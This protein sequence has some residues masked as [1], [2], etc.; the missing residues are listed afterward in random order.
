MNAQ[1]SEKRIRPLFV[2]LLI[3]ALAAILIPVWIFTRSASTMKVPPVSEPAIEPVA[4]APVARQLAP[5]VQQRVPLPRGAAVSKR[6]TTQKPPVPPT[7]PGPV[8]RNLE[9]RWGIR[10]SSAQLT[11]GNAFLNLRYE[12]INPKKAEMLANGNTRAYVLDRVTRTRFY[13][14][15]PPKEGCFPPTGN[16]LTTNTTYFAMIGN[17]RGILKSGGVV[18]VV[19]G[20]ATLTDVAIE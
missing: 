8:G 11:M 14:L 5:V 19:V 4:E 13:M 15:P 16:R 3:C 20:D 10:V 12:V 1:D 7:P 9:E 17:R 18:N 2:V 6:A